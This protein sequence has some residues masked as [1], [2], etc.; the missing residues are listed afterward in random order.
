MAGEGPASRWTD[1]DLQFLVELVDDGTA[2]AG[3]VVELGIQTWA[4]HGHVPVDGEILLA[5][6]GSLE[7]ARS[8][9]D[10]IGR[11]R[12]PMGPC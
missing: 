9:L 8:V 3:D 6:F 11:E 1:A 4:I 10:R 7:E 5:E 12:G 2:V